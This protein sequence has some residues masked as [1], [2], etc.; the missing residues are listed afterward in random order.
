M[1]VVG[2]CT[3][4]DA[5]IVGRVRRPYELP[6]P[7][8]L[9]CALFVVL[10]RCYIITPFQDWQFQ[11][12][13]TPKDCCCLAIVYKY[14]AMSLVS[15]FVTRVTRLPNALRQASIP[16]SVTSSFEGMLDGGES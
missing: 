4:I 3:L 14:R 6:R 11:T 5:V 10:Y 2:S 12:P 9:V 1:T 8:S 16:R 13:A 7:K 15:H